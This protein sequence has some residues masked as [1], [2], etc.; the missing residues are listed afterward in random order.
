[1]GEGWWRRKGAG[2]PFV[3]VQRRP[4][5]ARGNG[6]NFKRKFTNE[7][8]FPCRPR[9]P[10]ASHPPPPVRPPPHPTLQHGDRGKR[11]AGGKSRALPR[12]SP[13]VVFYAFHRPAA[14]SMDQTFLEYP[15]FSRT[16]RC[17]NGGWRCATPRKDIADRKSQRGNVFFLRVLAA[18]NALRD[19]F[20]DERPMR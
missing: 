14:S 13:L 11:D 19:A 12:F 5:A 4:P 8:D 9:P 3:F 6:R 7:G 18:F 17:F 2:T 10:P 16:C 15:L 20:I 1:M